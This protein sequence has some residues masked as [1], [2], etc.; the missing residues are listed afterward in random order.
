MPDIKAMGLFVLIN[1][2]ACFMICSNCFKDEYRT[3]TIS[4]NFDVNGVI[5]TIKNIECEQCPSCKDIIFTH[6]QSLELDKKRTNLEFSAK[7]ITR[8]RFTYL[9]SWAIFF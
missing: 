3:I 1:L 9:M 6:Q 4:K 8:E 2:E 5:K 7:P